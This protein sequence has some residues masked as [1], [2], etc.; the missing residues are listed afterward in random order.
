MFGRLI[1]ACV[2]AAVTACVLIVLF[3]F[4][5]DTVGAAL[6]VSL[7]ALP[8]VVLFVVSRHSPQWAQRSF[9]LY[10]IPAV[11]A[12]L[13]FVVPALTAGEGHGLAALLG[14]VLFGTLVVMF[15]VCVFVSPRPAR[16]SSGR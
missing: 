4:D 11:A 13:F 12:C 7:F 15:P 8:S 16:D 9:A 3:T 14:T 6:L 5:L 10:I 1:L 2:I